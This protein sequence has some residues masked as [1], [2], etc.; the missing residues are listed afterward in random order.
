M[1]IRR[2]T[3]RKQSVALNLTKHA[4]KVPTGF[5]VYIYLD[6]YIYIYIY[7][8]REREIGS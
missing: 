6:I 4:L 7:I 1:K 8:E 3:K 5:Q 2:P